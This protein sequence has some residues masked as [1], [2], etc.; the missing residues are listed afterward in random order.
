MIR[1]DEFMLSRGQFAVRA[2]TF[3]LDP[4]DVLPTA[5]ASVSAVWYR[6]KRGVLRACT[7]TLWDILGERDR[8]WPATAEE[9]LRRFDDGRYGGDCHGR[10]DGSRYWGA[11]EPAVMEEHLALLRPM[12]DGYPSVPAGYQGWWRFPTSAELRDIRLRREDTLA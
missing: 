6:K 7:G 1:E 3:A 12:I 10:W 4:Y 2:A 8:P 11:Q 5:R 9:W